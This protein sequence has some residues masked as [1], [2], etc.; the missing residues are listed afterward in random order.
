MIAV[1]ALYL[2]SILAGGCTLLGSIA[3]FAK[4]KWSNRSLGFFLG[5]AAGVMIAVVFMDMLPSALLANAIEAGLGFVVGLL[6]L[7]LLHILLLSRQAENEG[8]LRLGYLIML[9]IALHDLPEGMAIALGSEMKV[10]TGMVIALAI[11]IHNIPEGMA[12]AA[13]LLMGGMKRLKIFLRVF[14]V[15]LITPLGTLTGQVLVKI[16][17]EVLAFL[18]GLAS[19]VMVFLVLFYLWPQAGSKDKKSRVQGFLLGLLIIV[20]ATFF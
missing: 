19:G 11:G 14:L 12:I 17:P 5:L 7:A 16:V 10:R 4:R 20:A 1:K 9:G 15:S 13:P 18:L 3:L 8:L 2:M 6:V